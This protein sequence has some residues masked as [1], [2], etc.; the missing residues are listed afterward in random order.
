MLLYFRDHGPIFAQIRKIEKEPN[1][2][3]FSYLFADKYRGAHSK[4][5]GKSYE[6]PTFTQATDKSSYISDGVNHSII[7]QLDGIRNIS[8]DSHSFKS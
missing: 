7:G 5:F 1:R 6:I 3:F 4:K 2:T 8:G